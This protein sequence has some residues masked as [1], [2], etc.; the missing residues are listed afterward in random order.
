MYPRNGH[1]GAPFVVKSPGN[2]KIEKESSELIRLSC[3]GLQTDCPKAEETEKKEIPCKK[4][5]SILCSTIYL[6][7]FK[8]EFK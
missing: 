4:F 2:E 5:L 1:N 8:V 3:D 6:Y 7:N